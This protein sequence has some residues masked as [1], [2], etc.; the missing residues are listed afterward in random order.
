MQLSALISIP[1]LRRALEFA[2]IISTHR[3]WP[4]KVSRDQPQRTGGCRRAPPPPRQGQSRG[5]VG[6]GP[7][8]SGMQHCRAAFL[9]GSTDTCIS[10][11]FFFSISFLHSGFSAAPP[12]HPRSGAGLGD[13]SCTFLLKVLDGLWGEQLEM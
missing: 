12:G 9:P 6:S 2:L 3:V 10:C 7:F 1:A 8:A 13:L 11:L 5:P 4:Q